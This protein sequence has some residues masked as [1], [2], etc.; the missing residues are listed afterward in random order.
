M[1]GPALLLAGAQAAFRLGSR[2]R[3]WVHSCIL[4]VKV[5]HLLKVTLPVGAGPQPEPSSRPDA[6]AQ[7]SFTSLSLAAAGL[8]QLSI[9][10]TC[11]SGR[12]LRGAS[13]ELP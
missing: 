5:V 3:Q 9:H 8:G 10:R 7:K 11:A 13:S 6:R 12:C 4:L 2:G 1:C